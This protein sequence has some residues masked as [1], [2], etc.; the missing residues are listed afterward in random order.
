MSILVLK[1]A[2]DVRHLRACA[3]CEQLGDDR[4]MVDLLPAMQ[5]KRWHPKCF[6]EEFG[7]GMF[8]YQMRSSDWGK[9]RMSDVPKN[10]M[11]KILERM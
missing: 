6:Y 5:D 11:I 3:K 2:H 9:F 7:E 8:Q 4:E 10:V 1:T